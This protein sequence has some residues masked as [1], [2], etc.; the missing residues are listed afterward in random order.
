MSK[1]FNSFYCWKIHLF[2]AVPEW[3]WGLFFWQFL[4]KTWQ[5]ILH[6]SQKNKNALTNPQ[7]LLLLLGSFIAGFAFYLSMNN[8]V[9][10]KLHLG[11]NKKKYGR[12]TH[13]YKSPLRDITLYL[14]TLLTLLCIWG[15]YV[16]PDSDSVSLSDPVDNRSNTAWIKD[17]I[18]WRTKPVMLV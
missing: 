17:K 5:M 10:N 2:Y 8:S 18:L 12:E 6:L 14:Q 15:L 7:I 4:R 16:I 1:E 9:K 3:Q 11:L 13:C